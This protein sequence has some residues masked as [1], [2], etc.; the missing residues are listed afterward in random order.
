MPERNH[1]QTDGVPDVEI[2]VTMFIDV[3]HV[4]DDG[5]ACTPNTQLS[6]AV[7]RRGYS[8]YAP[9]MGYASKNRVSLILS[10][11]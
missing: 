2:F 5:G 8:R 7:A 10:G 4:P 6:Y 3:H 11:H 1:N 9:G